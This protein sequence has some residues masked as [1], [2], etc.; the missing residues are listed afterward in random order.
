MR[1]IYTTIDEQLAGCQCS[2]CEDAFE[3]GDIMALPD[4]EHTTAKEY[5]W[6]ETIWGAEELAVCQWCRQY[7]DFT[8]DAW[9]GDQI[10]QHKKKQTG[11]QR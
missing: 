9:L 8:A 11:E 4:Y 6:I 1:F 5:D 10:A 7:S 3:E 2:L